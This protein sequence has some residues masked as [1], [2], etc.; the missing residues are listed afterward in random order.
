[1]LRRGDDF[2]FVDRDHSFCTCRV[3]TFT[4]CTMNWRLLRTSV[5]GV[6]D[7]VPIESTTTDVT[8][9]TDVCITMIPKTSKQKYLKCTL[10]IP[11]NDNVIV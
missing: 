4:T 8:T 1:M 2:R 5:A 7:V 10:K 3:Y 11:N 9:I 6:T